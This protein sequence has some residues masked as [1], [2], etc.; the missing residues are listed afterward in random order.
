M[1]AG[2]VGDAGSRRTYISGMPPKTPKRPAAMKLRSGASILRQRARKIGASAETGENI[3]TCRV[4]SLPASDATSMRECNDYL[5]K[6]LDRNTTG[7]SAWTC[8]SKNLR[9]ARSSI[10]SRS[11]IN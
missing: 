10:T 4:S 2:T 3:A 8:S 9:D 6:S 1:A 11:R 7:R 5:K